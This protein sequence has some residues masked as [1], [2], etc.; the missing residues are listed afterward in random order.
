[1]TLNIP[2]RKYRGNLEKID[3][4]KCPKHL[5]WKN[6]RHGCINCLME[7][8]A[9]QKELKILAGEDPNKPKPKVIIRKI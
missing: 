1:M 7:E 6:K 3:S 4:K 8:E 9:R 2:P 5:T